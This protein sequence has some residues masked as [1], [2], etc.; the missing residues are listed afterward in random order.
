MNVFYQKLTQFGTMVHISSREK[1]MDMANYFTVVH[2]AYPIMNDN[3]Q[4]KP[5]IKFNDHCPST[6]KRE[7]AALWKVVFGR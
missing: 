7:V 1:R 4:A 5:A 6:V 2:P 3:D